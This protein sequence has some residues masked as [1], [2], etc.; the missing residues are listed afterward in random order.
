MDIIKKSKDYVKN[1]FNESDIELLSYHNW[2][3]TINVYNAVILISENTEGVTNQ[4]KE[5]LRIAALFHD[6]GYIETPKNHEARGAKIAEEFLTKEGVTKENIEEVKRLILSTKLSHKPND[7]L[8]EIISDADLSHLGRKDYVSTT[9]LFLSNELARLGDMDIEDSDWAESCVEFLSAHE[10]HTDYAKEIYEKT[11]LKNLEKVKE[12]ATIDSKESPEE[13]MNAELDKSEKEKKKKDKKDKKDK[14]KKKEKEE[15]ERDSVIPAKL[16]QSNPLKGVETLL[17]TTL[18]NHV[19]LSAIADQKANTL[20]SVNAIIISI[21]LS[22][23][24]PKLDSNPFLFYPSVT[25]L[26]SCF[27]TMILAILSTIPNVTNGE[28]TKEE[29]EREEGNIM[30]FG[31]FHKMKLKDFEW[32]MHKVWEKK[33]YLYNTMARDLFFL[34]VVLN[35]KYNLLRYAYYVFVLGLMFSI[36]VFTINIF[37]YIGSTTSIDF[38]T[39]T[40][41]LNEGVKVLP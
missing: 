15:K 7:I 24:F 2:K 18:R 4:Q 41:G 22:A 10:Y 12:L 6:I 5:N 20:I 13:K 30:F 28:I 14:K 21:V 38:N 25:I 36:I 40:E 1:E 34:G 33:S 27:I 16:D 29:I 39:A 8:E 3:H 17:K 35:K 37:P 23:L 26:I 32:S 11:K 31:N 9:Y 19:D